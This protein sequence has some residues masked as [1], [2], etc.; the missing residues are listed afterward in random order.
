MASCHYLLLCSTLVFHPW[1]VY[2]HVVIIRSHSDLDD[3]AQSLWRTS[4]SSVYHGGS[5]SRP[6]LVVLHRR[7]R[8]SDRCQLK[9]NSSDR[10]CGLWSFL[11]DPVRK[12]LL[13]VLDRLRM[14]D[15]CLSLGGLKPDI[16][17]PKSF[18]MSSML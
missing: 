4:T 12:F 8:L 2:C 14:L 1:T 7:T 6:H 11:F 15:G 17:P 18:L 5:H 13:P 9:H 16:Q 10:Y 3:S